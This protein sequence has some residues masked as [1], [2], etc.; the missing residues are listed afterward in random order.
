MV[1]VYLMVADDQIMVTVYL[2][3]PVMVVLQ[4]V[5]LMVVMVVAECLDERW[6]VMV[7]YWWVG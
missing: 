1:M 3:M 7:L 2:M 4:L 5:V 6:L